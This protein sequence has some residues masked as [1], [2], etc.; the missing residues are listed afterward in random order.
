LKLLV[1]YFFCD[2]SKRAKMNDLMIPLAIAGTAVVASFAVSKMFSKEKYE[3]VP[4]SERCLV[5]EF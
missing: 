1:E 3:V 4:S 2:H 5:S